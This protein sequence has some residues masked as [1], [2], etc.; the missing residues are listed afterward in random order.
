[1]LD[2]WEQRARAMTLANQEA[3]KST[4]PLA[5]GGMLAG[6]AFIEKQPIPKT[7]A[8]E[9][10]EPLDGR[11]RF[12]SGMSQ[13]S[14]SFLQPYRRLRPAPCMF[15]PQGAEAGTGSRPSPFKSLAAVQ[16]ASRPGDVIV[17]LASPLSVLP[18]DGGIALKAGQ[19]LVGDGPSVL[20]ATGSAATAARI[21]NTTPMNDGDAVVMAD[22]SSVANLVIANVRRSAVYWSD[23]TGVVVERNVISAA[24][25]SCTA[26]KGFEGQRYSGRS[27]HG[28]AAIMGD[29]A[30]RTASFAV[31]GNVIHDGTCMDGIHVRA[32][33]NAVVTG[34]IDN[35]AITRP[36]AGSWR[37]FSPRDRPRDERYRVTVGGVGRQLAILYREHSW[38]RAGC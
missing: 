25:T 21:T 38:R 1:M 30:S 10:D 5:A 8:G 19:R 14:F 2:P 31:V 12:G 26:G 22:N 18:L 34:R 32:G 28:Y 36:A 24:N 20:S 9:L 33:G 13:R 17:V 29:Y 23:A 3:P 11:P 16:R 37:R 27:M 35:N 7:D 15:R 6:R 4:C